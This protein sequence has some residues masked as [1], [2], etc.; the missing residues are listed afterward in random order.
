MVFA[1]NRAKVPKPAIP[2]FRF[3]EDEAEAEI[4]ADIV[5]KAKP[6]KVAKDEFVLR[7]FSYGTV[8]D[9]GKQKSHLVLV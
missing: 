8:L 5:W 7:V 4:D 2:I 9:Q 6:M 3:R 1:R